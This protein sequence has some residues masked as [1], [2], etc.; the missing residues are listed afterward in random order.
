MSFLLPQVV[1]KQNATKKGSGGPWRAFVRAE[2]KH[3]AGKPQLRILAQRY[4][5]L[6]SAGGLKFD[7]IVKLGVAATKAGR[8]RSGMQKSSF[9]P[10]FK[11]VMRNHLASSMSSLW[12]MCSKVCEED[13]ARTLLQ[14]PLVVGQDPQ[15]ILQ[16]ANTMKKYE[17]EA[18]RE[19]DVVDEQVLH[20]WDATLGKDQLQVLLQQLPALSGFSLKAIPCIDG[21]DVFELQP[22]AAIDQGKAAAAYAQRHPQSNLGHSLAQ[23]WQEQH[24]LVDAETCAPL[25]GSAAKKTPCYEANRQVEAFNSV[26]KRYCQMPRKKRLLSIG[27]LAVLFSIETSDNADHLSDSNWDGADEI[28]QVV[29]GIPL[30][31]FKP[32]RATLESLTPCA[33]PEPWSPEP[34]SQRMFVK[35]K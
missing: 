13:R 30:M 15:R 22:W 21:I 31:Y 5:E 14:H 26:L 16:I 4:R 34:M 12:Q 23:F 18:K 28:Q 1:K 29:F 10:S 3:V 17:S 35:V 6:K 25:H 27:I 9:G 8:V 20:T 33:D 19:A 7:R 32:Y 24:F 2:T 11:N